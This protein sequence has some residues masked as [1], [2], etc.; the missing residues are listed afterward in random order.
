MLDIK[1]PDPPTSPSLINLNGFCGRKAECFFLSVYG[2]SFADSFC[3][4]LFWHLSAV[5][6]PGIV[7]MAWPLTILKN[8]ASGAI[9]RR[10]LREGRF[11]VQSTSDHFE[12]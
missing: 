6:V 2:R 9:F 7:T 10:C 3:H 1:I 8:M 11:R 12:V 5:G 4:V